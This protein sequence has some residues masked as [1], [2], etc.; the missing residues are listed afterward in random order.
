[1]SP[2]FH[3]IISLSFMSLKCLRSQHSFD[4]F[5]V[6]ITVSWSYK[7]KSESKVYHA[8]ITVVFLNPRLES[9]DFFRELGNTWLFNMY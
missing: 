1:M 7:E 3:I 2:L 4:V 6:K 8:E 9:E 5:Q